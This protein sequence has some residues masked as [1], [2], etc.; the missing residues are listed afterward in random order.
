ATP[1][2]LAKSVLDQ[3]KDKGKV[4]R[5]WLGVYIQ[6]LTPETAESLGISGRRGAL[7]S[8][9]T[10]GGP[11]EKAGIRSGDVIVGFD[12]KEIRD[13]HDLPQLV[14]ATKPGKTADVRLIRGGKE[15]TVAVT[16]AEMAGEPGKPAGGHD[17]STK[18]LGLTVQDITPEIAQRLDIENTKGVVVTGVADGSPAE[19]AGFNEGDIIRAILHQ[20]KRNAVTNA[21]EFGK[22]VKKFHSDKTLL[23]L[24]ERGDARILL[25]VKNR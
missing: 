14:A 24:V 22:L 7:V 17:L 3:L 6:P 19:D 11:A 15:T 2:Q 9:V 13:Q 20:D 25:T 5:G 21:A 12:G 10:S 4:T 1:I 16:I 8:D 23:F 18:N